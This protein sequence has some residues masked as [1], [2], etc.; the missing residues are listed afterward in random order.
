LVPP[1]RGFDV[2]LRAASFLFVLPLAA[3]VTR[4]LTINDRNAA[5]CVMRTLRQTPGVNN[6]EMSASW[7]SGAYHPAIRYSY[8]PPSG[9]A[10]PRVGDLLEQRDADGRWQFAYSEDPSPVSL[11]PD[12]KKQLKAACGMA[13]VIGLRDA[14]L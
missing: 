14:P 10:T 9:A 4:D 6:V 11:P 8:A 7:Q 1:G 13:Y 3:C 2:R 12:F 5:D